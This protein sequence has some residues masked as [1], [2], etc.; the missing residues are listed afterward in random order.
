[1]MVVDI[2]TE[3]TF[4][5]G[6]PRVLFEGQSMN[7]PFLVNYDVAPDGQR[8]LIL[9]EGGQDLEATQIHVV[10]NWFEELKQQVPVN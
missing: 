9:K 1:M 4:S 2:W 8:F 5:A 7:L 10:L 3:P 6:R